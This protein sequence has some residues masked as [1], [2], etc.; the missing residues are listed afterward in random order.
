[1]AELFVDCALDALKDGALSIP[2]LFLAYL[3][4]ELL[5][6]S[7]RLDESILH[8]Y[9]RKAGPAIGGL[10]GVIP[11]CGISGAAATLFSTGT[12]TVGTMLAVFFATSDEMLPIML[13]AMTDENGIA[14][15]SILK[16]VAGKAALGIAL[17][18]LVDAVAGRFFRREKDIHSFC[19]REHCECGEEEGSALH[20]AL[21]HTLKIALLLIAVNFVLNLLLELAGAERLSAT[22]FARPVVGELLLALLGLIPNCS[23]SVIITQTYLNGIIGLGG[24]FAGLLSNAGIGMLVLFRSNADLREN[25]RIVAV[26]F[27]LSALSG[28]VIGLLF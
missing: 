27:G 12:I 24:L 22:L 26:L 6:R 19:E 11:Q 7:R 16:I 10:L 4:M 1:M 5:E 9:S 13:S 25:L 15:S 18:Y 14:A 17:G 23:V 20:A 28:I 2:I 21:M 3:L 8:A